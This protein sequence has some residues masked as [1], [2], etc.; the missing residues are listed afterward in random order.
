[1]ANFNWKLFR[2]R[3]EKM[4]T[5]VAVELSKYAYIITIFTL[6]YLFF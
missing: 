1:M 3:I 4:N 6:N 5:T 2:N